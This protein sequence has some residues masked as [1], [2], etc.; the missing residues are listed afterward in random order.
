MSSDN[1]AGRLSEYKNKGICGLPEKTETKRAMSSKINRLIELI[2]SS[3][4][5]AILTG[6]GISTA[7]GIPDFRGPKGIWTQEEEEKKHIRQHKRKKRRLN[8]SATNAVVAVRAT[9]A[10]EIT[11]VLLKKDDS[12]QQMQDSCTEIKSTIAADCT[13]SASF[14]TA[15]PTITHRA[16]A[17]LASPSV[18]KI[19]Y[20]IT[21]NVDGLHMRS[22]IARDRHCFLHG[23]IFT[24]I[25]DLCR[26]E[27]FRNFDIGG[28]S[29]QK[30]GRKCEQKG[31]DGFL[32]DTI[33]DWEDALP[34]DDWQRAQDEC[35]KSDLVLALGTSLRIEP[36]GSLPTLGTKFVIVNKQDT[37][38]DSSAEFVIRANVDD[39][40]K[41]VMNGLG[42]ENWDNDE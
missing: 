16:I 36:A 34:E 17:Y 6:A 33:L 30:T 41:Q 29:F 2:K 15:K 32:R 1:Y 25:C 27:Y 3:R 11:K 14:E 40:M 37:P 7:A 10:A 9:A 38:Y 20:C 31:C 24:E 42:L 8:S 12:K 23:C 18:D 26:K 22:G 35:E 21:Q 4:H 28:V 19:Q 13:P 5:T 39:V